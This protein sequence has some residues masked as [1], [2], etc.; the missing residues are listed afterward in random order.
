[1]TCFP[2]KYVASKSAYV[3][4]AGLIMASHVARVRFHAAVKATLATKFDLRLAN[5]EPIMSLHMISR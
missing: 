3:S 5:R 2:R 1:M 4:G